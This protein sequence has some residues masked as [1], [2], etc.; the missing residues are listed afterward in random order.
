MKLNHTYLP[1]H[2]EGRSPILHFYEKGQKKRERSFME[3]CKL[4]IPRKLMEEFSRGETEDTMDL[5][6]HEK[7]QELHRLY[8]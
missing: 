7:H 8:Y 3:F 2:V 5:R 4:T 6:K 1:R